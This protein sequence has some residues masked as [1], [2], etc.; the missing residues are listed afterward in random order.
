M[1]QSPTQEFHILDEVAILKSKFVVNKKI[2]DYEKISKAMAFFFQSFLEV[3]NT[4]LNSLQQLLDGQ[5]QGQMVDQQIN[6]YNIF[7]E[8]EFDRDINI[9]EFSIK[10]R[11]ELLDKVEQQK[12]FCNY[13][14]TGIIGEINKIN[15]QMIDMRSSF[16]RI[17]D[18]DIITSRQAFLKD[19]EN[20]KIPL[21][22]L[23]NWSD[24]ANSALQCL[25]NNSKSQSKVSC[26]KLIDIGQRFLKTQT[27][28][29]LHQYLE[30][31]QVEQNQMN[32]QGI[33]KGI[34]SVVAPYHEHRESYFP[35]NR[36]SMY[37]NIQASRDI[38]ERN[39]T[40]LKEMLLKSQ[41]VNKIVDQKETF[42]KENLEENKQ[43][44]KSKKNKYGEQKEVND[45]KVKIDYNYHQDLIDLITPF[46][47]QLKIK[48]N[49]KQFEILLYSL[50]VF[51][52]Q[53]H[54][55][56]DQDDK[57]S[58][59]ELF[60]ELFK[61]TP[62]QD[63]LIHSITHNQPIDENLL[64]SSAIKEKDLD[65]SGSFISS[66]FKSILNIMNILSN[67]QQA[68]NF[69]KGNNILQILLYKIINFSEKDSLIQKNQDFMKN[70]LQH[71]L[72]TVALN[73]QWYCNIN[74]ELNSAEFDQSVESFE[75]F[76]KIFFCNIIKYE[77]ILMN[78]KEQQ[79]L[80]IQTITYPLSYQIIK[81]LIKQLIF[82]Y[83]PEQQSDFQMLHEHWVDSFELIKSFSDNYLKLS[84][85]TLKIILIYECYTN[86]IKMFKSV[87]KFQFLLCFKELTL[88]FH[89]DNERGT[90]Q[91]EQIIQTQLVNELVFDLKDVCDNIHKYVMLS[92]SAFPYFCQIYDYLLSFYLLNEKDTKQNY[93]QQHFVHSGKNLSFELMK[94]SGF[95][96][97]KQP[98][99]NVKIPLEKS[100]SLEADQ[101][102]QIPSDNQQDKIVQE[103]NN[104]N[105]TKQQSASF[106]NIST[107]NQDQNI[108]NIFLHDKKDNSLTDFE[109]QI[110]YSDLDDIQQQQP[111]E[112]HDKQLIAETNLKRIY[113]ILS[114]LHE[115]KDHI[116]LFSIYIPEFQR[117]FDFKQ[118]ELIVLFV[119][120]LLSDINEQIKILIQNKT[121]IPKSSYELILLICQELQK[122]DKITN[123]TKDLSYYE[124]ALPLLD[125]WLENYK[126]ELAN[127]T[128]KCIQN[129][130]WENQESVGNQV[131]YNSKNSQDFVS[132]L[133]K[134]IENLLVLS[135]P[136]S[137][138]FTKI[139]NYLIETILLD[140]CDYY[141][142]IVLSSLSELSKNIQDIQFQPIDKYCEEIIKED[143]FQQ[144]TNLQV[145]RSICLRLGNL[146][147]LADQINQNS[148]LKGQSIL[149]II[150]DNINF[151]SKKVSEILGKSFVFIF[152]KNFFDCYLQN[153][154]SHQ[155]NQQSIKEF[156]VSAFYGIINLLPNYKAY[157]SLILRR[158]PRSSFSYIQN[159]IVDQFEKQMITCFVD[160]N[161]LDKIQNQ[162]KFGL[163]LQNEIDF[164]RD[165]LKS[166]FQEGFNLSQVYKIAILYQKETSDLIMQISNQNLPEF[167]HQLAF[168]IIY[169]RKKYD[170]SA[171][172]YVTK[173][174]HKFIQK[175]TFNL[176]KFLQNI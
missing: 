160:I 127:M 60:R 28:Q 129:E 46:T 115:E 141:C 64:N 91:G 30:E 39:N 36:K 100:I 56:F 102:E 74:Y 47:D 173:H 168:R 139:I 16:N 19:Y 151:A 119:D 1:I 79:T 29:K 15:E 154:D 164:C 26:S 90:F 125:L 140:T 88:D 114:C 73:N 68:E 2:D 25:I 48:Y 112:S 41:N 143:I 71:L 65:T 38:K 59:K 101:T 66:K 44:V 43:K 136:Q 121:D 17:I 61:I 42:F 72:I 63:A 40:L 97:L 133:F 83:D 150:N 172:N 132:I 7:Q 86:Y 13:V 93:I 20:E 77:D 138:S 9:K 57:S 81:I 142:D 52:I 137:F 135:C 148:H 126:F 105:N 49:Q 69:E 78:I 76:A 23:Q 155:L 176:K 130:R 54:D 120:N 89:F 84:S 75:S 104:N 152:L 157:F 106:Q 87:K 149:E 128:T 80:L 111:G 50:I 131:Y 147:F 51:K 103:E 116:F 145:L 96:T 174:Q 163:F 109:N 70:L 107:K 55:I 98:S 37:Q 162:K 146:R 85:H 117:Q 62:E 58:I 14:Q 27:A 53:N 33:S 161:K 99:L 175:K 82:P 166:Y 124:I 94:I 167:D 34:S 24:D 8:S 122:F 169:M 18:E 144:E 110:Q 170:Q 165:Y 4:Y 156:S 92:H 31:E 158:V 45:L 123:F 21:T 67:K 3:Q 134:S 153:L 32:F 35:S 5:K 11:K 159:I 95:V 22:Q 118:H 108:N 6:I 10:L 12:K 171:K 113:K